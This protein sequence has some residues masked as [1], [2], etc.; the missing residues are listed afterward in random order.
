[1]EIIISVIAL[2]VS[3]VSLLS[4]TYFWS[5]QFRPIISLMVKTHTGGNMAI[6]L[7]LEVCNCGSL[8]ARDIVLKASATALTKAL[9]ESATE[10]DKQKWLSCFSEKIPLIHNGSSVTCSFGIVRREKSFWKYRSEIPIN[11]TYNCFWG[12]KYKDE[13]VV[14][15]IDSKSFTGFAWGHQSE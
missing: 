2:I 7:D 8:P 3:I 15:I 1:M 11:I 5:K 12:K 14:H 9:D 4:A 13:V 6:A 10:E